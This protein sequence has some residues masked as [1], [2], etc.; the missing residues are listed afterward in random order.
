VAS[1]R[2]CGSAHMMAFASACVAM[3]SS[4]I[5][6]DGV[7]LWYRGQWPW[8]Q[9]PMPGALPLYPW[10][11]SL[12]FFATMTAKYCRFEHVENMGASW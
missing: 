6:P 4:Y 3:Q 9:C 11:S 8:L 2:A 5:A 7:L 1:C 10:A 12:L